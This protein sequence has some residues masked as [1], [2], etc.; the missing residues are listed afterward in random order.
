MKHTVRSDACAPLCVENLIDL[1]HADFLH[2][3]VVG[4]EGESETD[5]VT[6]EYTSETVTRT[7]TVTG[8][9]VSP[10]MRWVGGV[11]A[12]YQTLRSTLHVHVRSGVCISY[13]RFRPGFDVPSVQPF[14]PTGRYSTRLDV[15]FNTSSAPQPFR[16]IMPRL[17]YVVSPQDN[18]VM[19]PQNPRYCEPTE[20]RDFHSRFDTP[21]NRY[22]YQLQKLIERQNAG[23]YS[24]LSDADPGRDITELLGMETP[25][26]S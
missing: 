21:G 9:P 16:F 4:G 24:Y 5:E 23:D 20:R 12:K 8:R 18:Y 25:T 22:R 11:R 15:T 7:R 3:E 14:V 19:R 26:K 10:V 13:P 17:S 6:V 1:T 2:G